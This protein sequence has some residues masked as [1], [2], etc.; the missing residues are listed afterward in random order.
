MSKAAEPFGTVRDRAVYL[1]DADALVL[2]DLHL[3]RVAAAAIDAPIDDGSAL[4]D[5]LAGLVERFQPAEVVLAGDVLDAFGFVPRA[6]RAALASLTDRVAE[7]DRS[8]VV[9]QGNHDTQLPELVDEPPAAAHELAD[10]TVVCHGHER[11]AT[12]GRRYVVGHDH[13]AIDIQGRRRPCYLHGPDAHDGADVLALPA[14]N[15]AVPGTAVNG[16]AD[17]DPLSPFLAHAPGFHPV[18]W[19]AEREEPLVFPS[20]GSLQP[21]L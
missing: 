14:F 9:L 1:P 12:T 15:P 11:P 17:G 7:R 5:R 18:V 20:L 19:D 8:L 21:Y 3:G 16:W 4:V 2:A 10:G 13:P 6:A